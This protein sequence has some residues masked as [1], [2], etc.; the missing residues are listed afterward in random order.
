MNEKKAKVI[1]YRMMSAD[2]KVVESLQELENIDNL[3]PK[4]PA[5]I[6]QKININNLSMDDALVSLIF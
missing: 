6:P 1:W 2:D 4:T 3:T 5:T